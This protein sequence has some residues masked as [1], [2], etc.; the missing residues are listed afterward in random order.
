M[1]TTQYLVL[2]SELP[3]YNSKIRG[4]FLLGPTAF[5][6]N[7]SNPMVVLSEQAENIQSIFEWIGMHEFMPNYLEFKSWLAHSA[8]TLSSSHMEVCRSFYAFFVGMHS[9]TVNITMVPTYMS[10]TP[11]GSSLTQFTHFAQQ[12]RNGGKF[13]KFDY[14]HVQ[15]LLTYGTLDPPE[16]SLE[17]VSVPT[18]LFVGDVDGFADPKDA[19][20]LASRIQNVII[21][22][23]VAYENWSHLGFIWSLEAKTLIYDKIV[24]IMKKMS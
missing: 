5:G 3:E 17:K 10:H 15:N 9:H 20:L 1:G 24:D 21:N 13:A 7:A 23:V 8:C 12:F 4:G 2:L 6:G 19:D 11:A 16:Y 22:E 14:G 18:A